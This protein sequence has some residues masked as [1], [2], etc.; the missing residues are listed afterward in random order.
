M[1]AWQIIIIAS[2]HVFAI[3]I[4]P[5]SNVDILREREKKT[6]NTINYANL[7]FGAAHVGGNCIVCLINGDRS[8]FIDCNHLRNNLCW[9]SLTY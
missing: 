4:T 8:A 7:R 6:A 3:I 9:Y 1:V 5:F 2:S